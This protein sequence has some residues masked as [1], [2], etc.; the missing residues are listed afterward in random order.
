M[1]MGTA[2]KA[3]LLLKI[4]HLRKFCL[5]S[6]HLGVHISRWSTLLEKPG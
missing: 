1:V 4:W 3:T 2:T 5:G 6:L